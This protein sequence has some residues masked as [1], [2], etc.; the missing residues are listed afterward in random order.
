MSAP[1][2]VSFPSYPPIAPVSGAPQ[3]FAAASSSRIPGAARTAL[4]EFSSLAGRAPY[5]TIFG[6]ILSDFES[7]QTSRV[8]ESLRTLPQRERTGSVQHIY[9]LL[10]ASM[11][12]AR[13]DPHQR[14]LIRSMIVNEYYSEVSSLLSSLTDDAASEFTSILSSLARNEVLDAECK[15]RKWPSISFSVRSEVLKVQTLIAWKKYSFKSA[16]NLLNSIQIHLSR[17]LGESDRLSSIASQMVSLSPLLQSLRSLD[18]CFCISSEI[19]TELEARI[20]ILH[21]LYINMEHLKSK[22]PSIKTALEDGNHPLSFF[23][24]KIQLHV[25]L[26]PGVDP[27]EDIGASAAS[28]HCSSSLLGPNL[29]WFND[30]C[31]ELL[32][33]D[34]G[35]EAILFLERGCN[36]CDFTPYTSEI[37]DAVALNALKAQFTRDLLAGALVKA[38]ESLY[39]D[40]FR[41]TS[42]GLSAKYKPLSPEAVQ[43]ETVSCGYDRLSSIGITQANCSVDYK[44]HHA[45][46]DRLRAYYT[47]GS[48]EDIALAR[49]FF[50]A[51]P[52]P[53]KNAIYGVTYKLFGEGRDV[54]DLGRHIWH[55]DGLTPANRLQVIE[56][57]YAWG[58]GVLQQWIPGIMFRAYD[59]LKWEDAPQKLKSIPKALV[60]L[61]VLSGLIKGSLDNSSGNT[62]FTFSD[63]YRITGIKEFDDELSL[64]SRGTYKDIRLW[65]LGLPQSAAPFDRAT[66]MLFAGA[67]WIEKIE[68][69]NRL[70]R[71]P[72]EIHREQKRRLLAIIE[73]FNSEIRKEIITLTPRDLFFHIC[74]GREEYLSLLA[75]GISPW[76]IFERELSGKCQ[77]PFITEPEYVDRV[78]GN[79]A[80]L[81]V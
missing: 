53:I 36:K 77:M 49:E 78:R 6:R 41:V 7:G 62:I 44:D 52:D 57:M 11:N 59:L 5:Q 50:S 66:L 19:V 21:M 63:D 1:G 75:S 18:E 15:T 2:T 14:V 61:H 32:T 10:L 34:Y 68:R 72:V 27:S 35:S 79:L 69:Y 38:P 13:P 24:R 26:F 73:L 55:G 12:G 23:L 31:G 17:F 39:K 4:S 64:P 60:H 80:A 47:R 45:A 29:S 74:G 48:V 56:S 16:Q 81:Y 22:Y 67:D 8:I 58:R 51:L 9:G 71:V 3:A 43:C 46:M 37:A 25:T 30:F 28:S 33:N 76:E 70:K 42:E 20:R 65:Q 40:V 54:W